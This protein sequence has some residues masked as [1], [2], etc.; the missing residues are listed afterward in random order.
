LLGLSFPL[1][2][3]PFFFL[4][5]VDAGRTGCFSINMPKGSQQQFRVEREPLASRQ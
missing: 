4:G 2:A 1:D 5:V 3:L